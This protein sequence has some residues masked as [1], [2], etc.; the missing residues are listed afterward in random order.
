MHRTDYDV[1]HP[2]RPR[3]R[4]YSQTQDQQYTRRSPI[5]CLRWPRCPTL[6]QAHRRVSAEFCR[7][8]TWVYVLSRL[9]YQCSSLGCARTRA[10]CCGLMVG[11]ILWALVDNDSPGGIQV[12]G[13]RVLSCRL[14][15]SAWYMQEPGGPSRTFEENVSGGLTYGSE[16]EVLTWTNRM[17]TMV[18]MENHHL[19]LPTKCLYSLLNAQNSFLSSSMLIVLTILTMVLW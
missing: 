15:S 6:L 4:S 19:R 2:K 11:S 18:R 14:E 1:P 12:G 3:T 10:E 17:S 5:S 16:K 13:H 7:V 9:L 8:G